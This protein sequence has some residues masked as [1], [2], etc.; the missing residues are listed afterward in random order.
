MDRDLE[1]RSDDEGNEF[2]QRA[3]LAGEIEI[4]DDEDLDRFEA[5][6]GDTRVF[7]L[8]EYFAFFVMGLPM[9]WI[10]SMII[11]AAPYFQRRFAANA[12]ILRYFQAS[13]LVFFATTMFLTT[14]YLNR[15]REQPMYTHRLWR[16]LCGYVAVATLLM[17]SAIDMFYV[18]AEFYYPF[19]LIMVVMTGM[20]NGLSQNA[21]FAFA[22][23]F[24]RTEY[25]PAVMTGEA[26]AGFIPSSIEIVS[27]LAFPT[28]YFDADVSGNSQASSLTIGYFFSALLVGGASLGA[29]A[30]LIPRSGARPPFRAYEMTSV[31]ARWSSTLKWPA[32]AN[33]SCLC[34][35]SVSSVFVTKITSVV[36]IDGAPT[37][38]RPEAFI[39]LSIVLWNIGD[40]LGSLIAVSSR[41]LIRRPFLI[42]VLSLA[43]IVFIPMYLMCN[44]DDRGSFAGDWFYLICVQLFFGVTHGW[45]SGASMMGVPVWVPEEDREEA[46]AFMGMTLVTGLVAGS[47]LGL[48][49]SR[50]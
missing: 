14:I 3:L 2:E 22:A 5:V 25:A 34:I 7:S 44:I 20:A 42:F 47:I 23:G 19:T 30:F 40:F 11:Q 39:P 43:R 13:Y 10:W 48:V 28:A 33:F 17:V 16:A 37:L 18:R 29:L 9:M 26:L 45:L 35:S 27:A 4:K 1:L 50:V 49:V 41:F 21:A 31:W 6:K 36:P 15:Q 32:L 8:S 24:G 38:L 12:A 46:G